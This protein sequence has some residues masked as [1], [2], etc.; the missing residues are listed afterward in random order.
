[1]PHA[2]ATITPPPPPL[3]AER[4]RAIASEAWPLLPVP[5][6]ERECLIRDEAAFLVDRLLVQVAR[7]SGAIAVAMG[8]GLAALCSGDGPMRLGYSGIGDYARESLSLAPR[9]A[10]E[11]AR[12]ARELRERP[13]L[14]EAVRA[15]EVSVK[16]AEAV[17]P[18]ARGEAEVFWVA[19]AKRET[20]RALLTAAR[21]G[22]APE[23]NGFET[24]WVELET[25]ERAVVDEAMGLAG[26]LLGAASPRWQR[27]EAMCQEF[28]GEHPDADDG[29]NEADVRAGPWKPAAAFDLEA[30]LETEY[31]RWHYLYQADPVP[32]PEAGGLGPRP[33]PEDRRETAGARGHAPRL[34]RA[35]RPPVP[36]P[37]EHG[38]VA[39]HAVRRPR[40]LRPGAAGDVG[41]GGGAKGV[42]RA[43]LV[44]AAGNPQG[45]AGGEAR[46]RAGPARRPVQKVIDRDHGWCTVPGCSRP[47]VHAHHIRYR[48]HGGG[49]DE[50]NQ[51]GLCA[52]L[53]GSW[54]KPTAPSP[55]APSG[56]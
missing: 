11:L 43:P 51:T 28:L 42:A 46:V 53:D 41:A 45:H 56:G 33:G 40:A 25:E 2:A 6:D 4:L 38:P 55:T 34:G 31:E 1:M 23:E 37:R 17:L 48:S 9:T 44:G 50:A 32:A 30:W 24:V 5:P 54:G 19:R 15:G 16:K 20:V 26:Q 29:G 13:L 12:L 35:A 27:L 3:F 8:E 49:D 21:G 10:L 47:A 36:A 52:A 14:R 39:G 18:M 22:T 7:A